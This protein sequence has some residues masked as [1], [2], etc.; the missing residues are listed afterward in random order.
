MEAIASR[1]AADS[2]IALLT[3]LILTAITAARTTIP[4]TSS[5]ARSFMCNYT[6]LPANH[7]ASRCALRH[8]KQRV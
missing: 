6:L 4:I 8:A 5:I 1:A 3:A 7:F 2:G